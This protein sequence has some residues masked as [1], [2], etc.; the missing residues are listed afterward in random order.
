MKKYAILLASL[1]GLT[2]TFADPIE[3]ASSEKSGAVWVMYTETFTRMQ[4]AYAVM[5]AERDATG[6]VN[7]NRMYAGVLHETCAKGHG[8]LYARQNVQAKWELIS[9]VALSS[10]VTIANVTARMICVAGK[11]LDKRESTPS[12]KKITI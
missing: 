1:L 9:S 6:R 5:V 11:D 2:S 7:E 10:P 8:S 3:I 12:K 4:D